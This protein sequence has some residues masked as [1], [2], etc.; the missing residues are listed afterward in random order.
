MLTN[1]SWQLLFGLFVMGASCFPEWNVETQSGEIAFADPVPLPESGTTNTAA[2]LAPATP[3]ASSEFAQI[4]DGGNNEVSSDE[5]VAQAS[6]NGCRSNTKRL[7]R[8][9]RARDDLMCPIDGFQLNNGEDNSVRQLS[10]T[11]PNA[12]QGGGSG[13][14]SGGNGEPQRR[15]LFAPKDDT[16]SYFFLPNRNRPNQNSE[17]CPEPMHS[18]PVCGRPS[19]A[20]DMIY[21][22]N[23]GLTIDPCYPCTFFHLLLP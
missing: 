23:S 6:S 15:L 2:S 18:V 12:P 20:Y 3:D 21:A 7:S 4:P 8:K 11:L 1:S 13:Q 5:L 19:D 22:D 14:N 16:N 17:I 9:M 10:P